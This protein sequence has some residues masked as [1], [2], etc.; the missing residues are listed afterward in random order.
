[1]PWHVCLQVLHSGQRAGGTGI[2]GSAQVGPADTPTTKL[3][4]VRL[5]G[6]AGHADAA[7]SGEDDG[8]GRCG[9]RLVRGLLWPP[10]HSRSAGGGAVAV[11]FGAGRWASGAQAGLRHC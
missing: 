7:G 4:Q 10:A 8:K 2:G 3:G 1:M 9:V 6:Q 11:Q 5:L